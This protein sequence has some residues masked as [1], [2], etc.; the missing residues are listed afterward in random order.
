MADWMADEWAWSMAV[1]LVAV[2]V[3]SW[4]ETTAV[5]KA[6]RKVDS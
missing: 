5:L 3:V 4:G 1:H 2:K 6:A